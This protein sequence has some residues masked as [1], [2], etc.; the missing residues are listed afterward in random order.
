MLKASLATPGGVLS[1]PQVAAFQ[2]DGYV[3]VPGLF[4]AAAMA[5]IRRWTDEVQA[6]PETAGR[7]MMYF[8]QSATGA[9]ILNR[10]ENVLPYHDGFRRVATGEEL[11]GGCGQLFGEPAVLFKDK[12]NFKL[13]G[14][15]GFDPHQDVQA[16]WSRYAPLHLTA[17]VTVDRATRANGCLEI[18]T[19]FRGSHELIGQEWEPLNAEQLAGLHWQHVE[20]EAGDVVFFDSFI[21]HRSA[22]NGTNAARRVLYY[23]Y[24]KASDGDHLVQYYTDKRASYPPDIERLPGKEYRYRV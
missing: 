17:L 18:A 22:P 3:I 5:D 19:D 13:P 11:Q 14:G 6:W 8:E 21:P 9:R 12:I 15:G 1:A 4:D 7:Q 24:N 10:M 16:G 23:T 20:A 2:R